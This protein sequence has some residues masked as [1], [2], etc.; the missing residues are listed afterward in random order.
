MCRATGAVLFETLW[1]SYLAEACETPMRVE[2]GLAALA[3]ADATAKK[4][5]S[6]S[7]RRNCCD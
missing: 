3:E 5:E 2:E 1:L 6:V 7:T 4:L